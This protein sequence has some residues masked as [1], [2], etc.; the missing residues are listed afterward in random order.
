MARDSEV[1]TS[2]PG[3]HQNAESRSPRTDVV[4]RW[5]L[6]TW[7][8]PLTLAPRQREAQVSFPGASDSAAPLGLRWLPGH[9]LG[10][11]ESLIRTQGW[12]HLRTFVTTSRSEFGP[13]LLWAVFSKA[14]SRKNCTNSGQGSNVFVWRLLHPP[15][16]KKSE[17]LVNGE[18]MR[19]RV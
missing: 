11:K 12:L 16:G 8:R 13:N 17:C 19:L 3:T 6:R 15:L 2:A 10:T 1:T 4:P 7:P 14:L 9:K 18:V 5:L